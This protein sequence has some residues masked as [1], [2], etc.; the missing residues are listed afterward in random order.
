MVD[1]QIQARGVRD[2]RV[3]DAMRKV[4]RHLFVPTDRIEEAYDDHPILLEEHQSTISQPY[5]VAYM[6]EALQLKGDERV[7]EV[8]AGSGYQAA[9]LATLAREVYAVERYPTQSQRTGE[10]L[11]TLGYDNVAVITG[12]GS[13]GLEQ[14]APFEAIIVTAAA[15]EIPVSLKEQLAVGGRLVIPVG[16]AHSQTLIRL[17]RTGRDD[18]RREE[19]IPCVFVPLVSS[20]SD[21]S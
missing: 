5:I 6:T 9:I 13:L 21:T 10:R 14:Y 20:D 1:D 12:D 8:G 4:P 11:K 15:R 17:T 2:S 7:L 18:Y 3:L 16:S 19:L